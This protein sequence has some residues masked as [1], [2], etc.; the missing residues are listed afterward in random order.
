MLKMGNPECRNFLNSLRG[1]AGSGELVRQIEDFEFESALS[2]L[3][4]LKKK[5]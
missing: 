5:L 2:S 3:E 4:D 1:I